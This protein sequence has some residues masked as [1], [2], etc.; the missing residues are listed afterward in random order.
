MNRLTRILKQE[1]FKLVRGRITKDNRISQSTNQFLLKKKKK[2]ICK[3][4]FR[5]KSDVCAWENLS[6]AHNRHMESNNCCFNQRQNPWVVRVQK[7][8]GFW[9]GWW[10][11]KHFKMG[12]GSPFFSTCHLLLI[13]IIVIYNDWLIAEDNLED[14]AIQSHALCLWFW[15]WWDQ[16]S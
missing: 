10:E 13:I 15:Q 1:S 3:Q 5:L 4:G 7:T 12:G 14:N 16:V 9:D 2:N 8:A 11:S 6:V